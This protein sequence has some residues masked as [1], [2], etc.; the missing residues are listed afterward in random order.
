MKLF[1]TF[2]SCWFRLFRNSLEEKSNVHRSFRTRFTFFK[3]KSPINQTEEHSSRSTSLTQ[4]F[5]SL[6]RSLPLG[7]RNSST[8]GHRH[9]LSNE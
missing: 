8:K 6:R 3:N 5:H 7:R 4:R 1:V 9:L 2:S